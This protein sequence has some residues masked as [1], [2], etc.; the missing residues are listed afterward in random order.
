VRHDSATRRSASYGSAVGDVR[1]DDPDLARR[2]VL[3]EARAQQA[4]NRELRDL[5]DGWLVFDPNDAEP[6]WNR[7]IAPRWPA[8]P[9]AFDRRLDEVITLF[10]TLDRLPHVRPLPLGG[11][12]E[13]LPRRLELAGFKTLGADR[14]MVLV[15]QGRPAD[16]LA[17][18]DA[19]VAAAFGPG[20]VAVSRHGDGAPPASERP[21]W[22]ERRR[23]AGDA[24]LVL[25]EAFGVDS[26]RR[27]ALENDVLACVSRPGCSIVLLRI[28]GEP[29]AIARR[30]TTDD[31][32]YLSSIGTRPAFRGRG[33]GALATA[34]VLSDAA[35]AGRALVHL[36][37]E[38]D[39]DPGRR[40]YESLGFAVVGEPAPDMLL[41]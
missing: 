22:G 6:F 41:R 16:R 14:R 23:W 13:D 27:I 39:N 31:G 36:S 29:V 20:R 8:E 26:A 18:A 2:L 12:P 38:I 11:E 3:H 24:A 21:R 10:A 32:S 19:R 34:L 17:A 28:D 5:G 1:V 4:P 9:A 15:D 37:V 33:L 25:E 30:A 35:E 7:L 40:L